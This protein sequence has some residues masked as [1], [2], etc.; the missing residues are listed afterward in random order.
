MIIIIINSD[1][2]NFRDSFHH[3]KVMKPCNCN[4]F[5]LLS[6]IEINRNDDNKWKKEVHG[7]EKK[8]HTYYNCY[9]YFN[10]VTFISIFFQLLLLL[11]LT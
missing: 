5:H 7:R 11:T 8:S 6:N 3:Q 10:K 1:D 2:N 4:E 9:M